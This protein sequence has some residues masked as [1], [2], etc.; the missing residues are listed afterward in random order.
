MPTGCLKESQQQF[1]MVS[2]SGVMCSTFLCQW[3]DHQCPRAQTRGFYWPRFINEMLIK[4]KSRK[5]WL[6]AK[7]TW[8]QKVSLSFEWTTLQDVSLENVQKANMFPAFVNWPHLK[9]DRKLCRHRKG[10]N[11]NGTERLVP[12][13]LSTQKETLIVMCN[14]NSSLLSFIIAQY[15]S[16]HFLNIH[17]CHRWEAPLL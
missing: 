4:R 8:C 10:A 3:I 11:T 5:S 7:L 15:L 12:C 13:N 9:M 6:I 16:K 1:T 17:A 14:I 2:K